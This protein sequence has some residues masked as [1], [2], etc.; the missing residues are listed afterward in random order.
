MGSPFYQQLYILWF[1]LLGINCHLKTIAYSSDRPYFIVII[2][3]LLITLNL[4]LCLI[5]KLHHRCV[6]VEFIDLSTVCFEHMLSI[7]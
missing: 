1:Q 7:L 3:V 2:V 5:Y 4:L 6:F